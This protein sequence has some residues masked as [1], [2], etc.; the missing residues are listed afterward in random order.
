[1][2]VRSDIAACMSAWSARAI[3]IVVGGEAREEVIEQARGD[4]AVVL[5]ETIENGKEEKQPLSQ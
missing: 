5:P 4:A 2:R 1:M 3:G